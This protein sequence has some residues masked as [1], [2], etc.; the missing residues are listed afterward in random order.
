ML[1]RCPATTVLTIGEEDAELQCT[2][3]SEDPEGR[4]K[5]DHVVQVSPAMGGEYTWPNENP[6]PDDPAGQ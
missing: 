6:L 1:N 3:M 2:V 4:H 5:G